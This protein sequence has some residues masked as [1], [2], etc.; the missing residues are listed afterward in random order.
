MLTDSV[1]LCSGFAVWLT[2]GPRTWLGGRY[3]SSNWD[4]DEFET[5]REEVVSGDKLKVRMV[6]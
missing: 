3:V 5:K 6:V 4:V 1:E 2:K